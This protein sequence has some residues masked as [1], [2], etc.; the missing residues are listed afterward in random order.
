MKRILQTLLS[1]FLVLLYSS[2]T[3]AQ[4]LV[5]GKMPKFEVSHASGSTLMQFPAAIAMDYKQPNNEIVKKIIVGWSNAFD[6]PNAPPNNVWKSSWNAGLS[7][8]A[9]I[10]TVPNLNVA[11]MIR[12][13][14]GNMVSVP[15]D[16]PRSVD[17]SSF[18]CTFNYLTSTNNGGNWSAQTG[19]TVTFPIKVFWMR[20]HRG[21]FQE[22]D[23]TL[24]AAGYVAY[25]G[26]GGD[27]HSVIL[28]STDNGKTWMLHSNITGTGFDET[29][30]SRCANGDWLAVMRQTF[31]S[32]TNYMPLMYSRSIDKGVTW[33][34]PA[35]LP[36]LGSAHTS[37]DDL[38]ESV[39]PDL[40]LMPNGVMVLSYGRP[41]VHLAFSADG[42]GTTWTNIQTT[43]T[44]TPG[45]LG[46]ETSSYT[47]IVPITGHRF[48]QFGDTGAN[49]NYPANPSP[50]PFSIWSK[51]IDIVRPQQ[52]RIDLK[53][54]LKYG[55]V[56]V[57]PA[58]TLTYSDV[59]HPESRDSA[60]FDGS[61][62]YWSGALGTN[63]GVFQIDLQASYKITDI[64]LA[65]LQGV[66]QSATVEYS[67]DGISWSSPVVNYTNVV[68]YAMNY[69]QVTP[70][71][72]RYIRVNVSGSGQ[73]GLSELE[74]YEASNTFENNAASA[75]TEPHG[76]MPAGYVTNGTS[77]T[78]YGFSVQDN[79]GC[80]SN[81]A[82]KLWD[83]SSTWRAGI[84]KNAP[85]SNT[86]TL[87]FLCRAAVVPTG[88]S[89][90]IQMLG[91]VSG[92]ESIAFYIAVGGDGKITANNGSGWAQVGTALFPVNTGN[93]RRIRVEANES[94]NIA[95]IYM[96][97][98]LVGNT[99]MYSNPANTT[100]LTGFAFGSNGT[101]TY[102]EVVY[103]D[104]VNLFDP[105]V[106]GVDGLSAKKSEIKITSTER[107]SA[108]AYPNPVHDYVYVKITGAAK[109]VAEVAL[110]NILG[111]T[112][113]K[114]KANTA[115]GVNNITL[116]I[117]GLS[118]GIYILTIS[119]GGN[120]LQQKVIIN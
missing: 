88:G 86:K 83:G 99:S 42:N 5:I 49:W 33:S 26:Y 39:D 70:F 112:V 95:S 102:G 48:N 100:N 27:T 107:F 97:G 36:G 9:A 51:Y 82:L 19:G 60:V 118:P 54:R 57:M 73:I 65:L 11:T 31:P 101:L 10:T 77:A 25:T 3:N 46:A 105:T 78:L 90:N 24:Y 79:Q 61:T 21:M 114:M 108:L 76:I 119:Q 50:N 30:I 75:S 94:A 34:T 37:S 72:A 69:T 106:N 22:N 116:P 67:T 74:L 56:T 98:V 47:A 14:N 113:K 1:A 103:F 15:F 63:S 87:E 41:N 7:Y 93:W 23:G 110:R 115:T 12:L 32:S 45:T 111:N 84:K 59:I 64:G 6:T 16:A 80:A 55:V 44:E 4:S 58:T 8:S 92:V 20:F 104:D 120:A 38:N 71:A 96:D 13:R 117:Q 43:F 53:K 2:E 35:Y 52:N 85:S 109:G 89:F 66:Q 29:V 62:D 28:K 91:T 81:R 18:V 68:H 40:L 17:P